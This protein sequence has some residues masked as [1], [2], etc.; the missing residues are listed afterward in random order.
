M[1]RLGKDGYMSQLGGLSSEE[2]FQLLYQHMAEG[3]ALHELVL[4]AQG[5]PENYRIIAVNPQYE[6]YTGLKPDQVR[7]KLGT[8]VYGT[9][10]PPYLKEFFEVAV[11]G[12][13]DS[14]ET[15]FPPL[16]RHYQISIAPLGS[17]GFAT[18]FLDITERKRQEAALR[19][20]EKRFRKMFEL[21]PYPITLSSMNGV[22]LDCN[23]VFLSQM[24][25][26]KN[27]VIGTRILDLNIYA[28]P[29]QRTQLMKELND[30]G[31][32]T[33]FEVK[34]RTKSGK[35]R[36]HQISVRMI[37]LGGEKQLLVASL[38]L[39]EQRQLEQKML[40][41][42]KLESLG[43]LAG[44]IAHDF[45]NLLTSILGNADLAKNEM[46]P[47]APAQISLAGIETAARRAADLC[48]QLLAYSGKGRFLIQ[49]LNLKELVDEMGHL[50]SVSI[51]KKAVIKYHFNEGIPAIEADAT[52]IRQV[53]MNLIVN[54]S[55][56]IGER[57]GMISITTGLAHCDEAYFRTCFASE[58]LREGEYVFLE[59]GDT[60]SGMDKAT[61]ERIFDPFF[62][63]KFTGRGLG[64]AAVLG[65]VRGHK[66]T[67]KIYSEPQRGTTFKLLFPAS[68]QSSMP[69]PSIVKK[70][71]HW[72]G[73][74]TVLLVDDEETI[75]AL[76]K[77]ML[78]KAGFNVLMAE[79]GRQAV[80]AFQ[81]NKDAISLVLLDL[82]MPHM[83]G[84]ACFRELRQI[85]KNVKVILSSGYNEQDVINRFA[86]KGL[87]GFIQKPYT[88]EELVSRLKEVLEA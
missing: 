67:I 58:G 62:T 2:L 82:T 55:E 15:Y 41:S 24:G 12:K 23:E 9:E 65:I 86:G 37:E 28:Y 13:A 36:D 83:D 47:L 44:G 34:S 48:R 17:N 68:A 7:G 64:L 1:D 4:D 80:E 10:S 50:L 57:S 77:R 22:F 6:N 78:E 69:V 5:Q 72:K 60:G 33:G 29:E 84:D 26:E 66:G 18:I 51:S 20:S 8:E 49:P 31:Q 61:L 75:R 52:Q 45:N 43:V 30:T 81:K 88:A 59:V 56:A 19:K 54:A 79:D 11:S 53:V 63:T 73:T 70:V 46:S 74:G 39:T 21:I 87:A 38:D 27:E 71:S 3:V 42:Q 76:G 35:L 16:N 32:V 85:N 40:Q 14:L 25:Y